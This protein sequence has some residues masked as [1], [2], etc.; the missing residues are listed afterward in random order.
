MISQ[1]L[2]ERMREEEYWTT[3]L[4]LEIFRQIDTHLTKNKISRSAFADQLGVS[5]GYVSQILNGDFD[6]KLSKLI[7]LLLAVGKV[8]QVQFADLDKVIEQATGERPRLYATYRAEQ[9]MRF[10]D[11]QTAATVNVVNA[12]SGSSI[13]F[14][15]VA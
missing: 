14:D 12:D 6:H 15:Q 5:R 1:P 13:I 9:T 4:Q 2:R 7:S 3:K 10:G 11:E 8:P